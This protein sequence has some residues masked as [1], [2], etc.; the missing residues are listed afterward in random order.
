MWGRWGN[1][2]TVPDFQKGKRGVCK[3]RNWVVCRWGRRRLPHTPGSSSLPPPGG[4]PS[5][6][7]QKLADSSPK[8]RLAGG[9]GGVGGAWTLFN[10]V[11]K[12][13]FRCALR[14]RPGIRRALPPP[15]APRPPPPAPGSLLPTPAATTLSRPSRTTETTCYPPAAHV[16]RGLML[17]P[18]EII[19]HYDSYL[20]GASA[21][22]ARAQDPEANPKLFSRS[23]EAEAETN[24]QQA[25]WKSA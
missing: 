5:G 9:W 21:P 2:Y 4:S 19:H 23:L 15:A 22:K 18:P 6:C 20:P 3:G 12:A 8:A 24:P 14:G 16:G 25:R 11:C 10:A 7:Y 13:A 1:R 17:Q